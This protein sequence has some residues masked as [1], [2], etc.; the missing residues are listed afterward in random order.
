MKKIIEMMR[1]EW[2]K[3]LSEGKGIDKKAVIVS[4]MGVLLVAV[5]SVTVLKGA[6]KPDDYK[7]TDNTECYQKEESLDQEVTTEIANMEWK[8]EKNSETDGNKSAEN[9]SDNKK[10]DENDSN[11]K[12]TT[13]PTYSQS[14]TTENRS[15]FM[16]TVSSRPSNR[17]SEKTSNTHKDTASRDSKTDT[18]NSSDSSSNADVTSNE[19]ATD[20]NTTSDGGEQEPATTEE[21]IPEPKVV[22]INADISGDIKIVDGEEFI[23]YGT[24]ISTFTISNVVATFD[25]GTTL[26]LKD[27]GYR[28]YED[29]MSNT[30]EPDKEFGDDEY[31]IA[32]YRVPEISDFIYIYYKDFRV[33]FMYNKYFEI[34]DIRPA[35]DGFFSFD[36][37]KEVKLTDYDFRVKY[38]NAE[39]IMFNDKPRVRCIG[40]IDTSE[41]GWHEMEVKTWGPSVEMCYYV[42]RGT[43]EMVLN[44]TEFVVHDEENPWE[45]ILEQIEGE[46]HFENGD[47]EEIDFDDES[48]IF[49]TYDEQNN[50]K[51]LWYRDYRLAGHFYSEEWAE[52]TIHYTVE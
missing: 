37:N 38:K 50:I 14:R 47:V 18:Q 9:S 42:N 31:W 11:N 27:S 35:C 13:M 44:E 30:P 8:Q 1:N 45:E 5:A 36:Y 10:S 23:T 26:E 49:L 21:T 15:N 33:G 3:K 24:D 19:P 25:D 17:N 2:M 29:F 34:S 12:M 39:D 52:A 46:L 28:A 4:A 22:N 16:K 43:C 48:E 40:E 20:G 32:F 6:R 51:V 7:K 41:S